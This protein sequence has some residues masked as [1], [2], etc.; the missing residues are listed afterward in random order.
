MGKLTACVDNMLS[1]TERQIVRSSP[2]SA[3]IFKPKSVSTQRSSQVCP[4][5]QLYNTVQYSTE[6]QS[7]VEYNT[8]HAVQY[9]IIQNRTTQYNPMQYNTTQYRFI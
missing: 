8:V 9:N 7:T 3:N 1:E 4:D 6:E 5:H 2:I